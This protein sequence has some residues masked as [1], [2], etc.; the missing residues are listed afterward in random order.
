VATRLLALALACLTAVATLTPHPARADEPSAA[1]RTKAKALIK[2]ARAAYE[3]EKYD[4]AVSEYEAAY[5]LLPLPDILFNLGQILRVKG[6]QAAALKAYRRYLAVESTGAH[7]DEARTQSQALLREVLPEP[8]KPRYDKTKEA[9]T[10][11]KAQK[12]NALDERWAALEAAIAE[13][14]PDL[15]AQLDALDAEIQKRTQPAPVLDEQKTKQAVATVVVTPPPKKPR[16]HHLKLDRTLLKKWWFWTAAGG[17]VAVL[18]T[19]ITVGAV[20][21]SQQSDPTASLGVIK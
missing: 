2:K 20:F 11:F 12:G 6:D 4:V 5:K 9:Y 13:G 3:A 19:A 14:L 17:I 18:V 15:E 16:E 10:A 21:G 8:L 7:A 1:Q